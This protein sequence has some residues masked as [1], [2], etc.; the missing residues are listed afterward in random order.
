MAGPAL[1]YDYCYRH[2]SIIENDAAGAKLHLATFSSHGD[3]HPHFFEG[4]LLR[5]GRAAELLRGL[6]EV[7]H[8]VRLAADGDRCTCPW[9]AKHRS[10]RGPCKH[11]LA[12]QLVVE[13]EADP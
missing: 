1:A 2:P 6:A 3:P 11:I 13:G 9:Y 4:R 10:E 12:V 7:E 5:P 8:L